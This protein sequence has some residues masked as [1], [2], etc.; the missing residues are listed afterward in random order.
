MS[1]SARARRVRVFCFCRNYFPGRASCVISTPRRF[2]L[3][4]FSCPSLPSTVDPLSLSHSFLLHRKRSG[5]F[6]KL[7]P[8]L[9]Q[10]NPPKLPRKSTGMLFSCRSSSST[11]TI[12]R[13]IVGVW[14]SRLK[15]KEVYVFLDPSRN[16]RRDTLQ[17]LLQLNYVTLACGTLRYRRARCL[18]V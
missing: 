10:V 8:F 18:A 1:A 14:F 4:G 17:T 3:A 6:E 16:H 5:E 13:D 15:A 9:A 2:L 7:V 12:D 11:S